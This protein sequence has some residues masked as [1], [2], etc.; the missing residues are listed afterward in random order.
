MAAA[1][2][3]RDVLH[4][5][6]STR[7]AR[8]YHLIQMAA[9][10]ITGSV[11][12]AMGESPWIS[13]TVFVFFA[14]LAAITERNIRHGD[15]K[16]EG[17][18]GDQ[19]SFTSGDIT[20]TFTGAFNSAHAAAFTKALGAGSRVEK[21]LPH[22]T[23][24]EP[25]RAWKHARIVLDGNRPAFRGIGRGGKYTADDVAI[26]HRDP[27]LSY[28]LTYY[29][30]SSVNHHKYGPVLDCQCGFYAMAGEAKPD[31]DGTPLLEVEL[32]GK[33]IVCEYGY[34]AERQRVLGVSL[35]RQCASALCVADASLFTFVDGDGVG[36]CEQHAQMS[37]QSP[38]L[39]PCTLSDLAGLLGTEVRWV[40]HERADA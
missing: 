2:R 4:G 29:G 6:T 15:R 39:T 32:Y 22:R 27:Y 19:S 9:Q 21:D 31:R 36:L 24:D 16:A 30:S 26:C 37:E 12:V 28:S 10:F 8:R 38:L 1:S 34:R 7:T 20:F 40:D 13:S 35:A 5:I 23:S 25:I 11:I 14:A 17:D 3:V 18:R 33:V